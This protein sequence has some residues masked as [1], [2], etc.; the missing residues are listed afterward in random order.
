MLLRNAQK[1]C[2]VL[3]SANNY[4]NEELLWDHQI[5]ECTTWQDARYSMQAYLQFL[6]ILIFEK[7]SVNFIIIG[8]G[9][10]GMSCIV[11]IQNGWE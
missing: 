11:E 8:Y 7:K 4:S 10:N 5:S 2:S 9:C 1:N 6:L 3:N